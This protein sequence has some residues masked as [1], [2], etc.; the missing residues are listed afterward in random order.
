[1]TDTENLHNSEVKGGQG[2][3]KVNVS[4]TQNMHRLANEE[5]TRSTDSRNQ[6]TQEGLLSLTAQRAVCE[7]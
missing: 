3:Y 5:P 6:D 1:V 2:H 4:Y 7:T